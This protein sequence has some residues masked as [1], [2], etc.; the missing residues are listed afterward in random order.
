MAALAESSVTVRFDPDRIYMDANLLDLV[1]NPRAVDGR[2]IAAER[3][4]SATVCGGV[5]HAPPQA[6]IE[7]HVNAVAAN[8]GA[9]ALRL[10][11][12]QQDG[13]YDRKWFGHQIA[14]DSPIRELARARAHLDEIRSAM[15]ADIPKALRIM[16]LLD[17]YEQAETKP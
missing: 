5:W 4:I 10:T 14:M 1:H 13:A 17:G 12:M 16:I 11:R 7:D 6:C 8:L 9:I 15:T 2:L 3:S